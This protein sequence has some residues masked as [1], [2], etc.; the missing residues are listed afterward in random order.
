MGT[1]GMDMS[2]HAGMM[3]M[4]RN[5][6]AMKSTAGPFGH[7]SMGGLVTILK[8]RDTLTSY[9]EDPGWYKHPAG[10]VALKASSEDLRRDGIEVAARVPTTPRR[11]P[12]AQQQGHGTQ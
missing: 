9:E 2:E 10:T 1:M 11:K 8:V 4:P 3:S 12:A 5:T 6:I 7:M